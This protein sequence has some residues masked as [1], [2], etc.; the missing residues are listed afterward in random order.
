MRLER[1][2]YGLKDAARILHE[3]VKHRC[4]KNGLKE[5]PSAL[6]VFTD[7]G[8]IVVCYVDDV[9]MFAKHQRDMNRVKQNLEKDFVF[10]DLGEPTN[11]QGM[12]IDRT[13][14]GSVSLKQEYLILKLLNENGMHEAKY[15][16]T[17][18]QEDAN[19]AEGTS[20]LD[21]RDCTKYKSIVGSLMYLAT[22]TQAGFML[23]SKHFVLSGV[24]FNQESE[25]HSASCTV[26]P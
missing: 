18:M 24:E 14:K 12:E 1:S 7:H 11:F 15:V 20:E 10:R 5:L 13:K 8:I 17:P 19:I 25:E 4:Q 6:C 3:L 21:G 16:R 9:L 2:L 26:I 23:S 22:K